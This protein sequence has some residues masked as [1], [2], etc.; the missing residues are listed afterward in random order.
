[1]MAPADPADR[2]TGQHPPLPKERWKGPPEGAPDPI[3]ESQRGCAVVTMIV[4]GGI[5]MLLGL[6]ASVYAFR[7]TYEAVGRYSWIFVSSLGIGLLGLILVWIALQRR[8]IGAG[9][10][11]SRS[12]TAPDS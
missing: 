10:S 7:I 12:E 8:R 3:A 4:L 2:G 11:A 9:S 5:L 6:C 1:M